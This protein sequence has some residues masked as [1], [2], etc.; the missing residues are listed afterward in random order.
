VIESFSRQRPITKVGAIAVGYGVAVVIAML[1]M[2]VYMAATSSVDRQGSGGMSAFGDSLVFLAAL[3][4]AA[5]PATGAALFVLR[6]R[7]AFWRVLSG[8]SLIVACTALLA[9]VLSF[10]SAWIADAAAGVGHGR[11]VED[12]RRSAAGALLPA[13]GTVRSDSIG[14]APSRWRRSDR[15]Y[16]LRISRVLVVA[17]VSLGRQ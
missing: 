8:G 1:V 5:I 17:V 15:D 11:A 10:G 14:A 4:V 16:R 7:P 9:L 6:S 12:P 13:L 2:R 3:G